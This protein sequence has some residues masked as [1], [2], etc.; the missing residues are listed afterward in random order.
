MGKAHPSHLEDDVS[1]GLG[2]GKHIPSLGIRH[3]RGA[4]CEKRILPPLRREPGGKRKRVIEIYPT[5]F[6]KWFLTVIAPPVRRALG[7]GVE[8]TSLHLRAG[9]GQEGAVGYKRA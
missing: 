8:N 5:A 4:R 3:L 7:G 6:A 2:G 1:E 9:E